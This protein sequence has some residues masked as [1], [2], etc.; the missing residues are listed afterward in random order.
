MADVVQ[1]NF[2][3]TSLVKVQDA[4]RKLLLSLNTRRVRAAHWISLGLGGTVSHQDGRRC[5]PA[6]YPH[7]SA[8][9]TDFCNG[10]ARNDREK[11]QQ[12]SISQNSI[13]G[14]DDESLGRSS[15]ADLKVEDIHSLVGIFFLTVEQRSS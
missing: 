6:A 13:V 1:F 7:S 8:M 10:S 2:K 5:P 3:D 14:V 12:A 15:V 11:I 4:A 9:H